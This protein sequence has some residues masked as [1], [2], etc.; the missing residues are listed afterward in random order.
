M[1]KSQQHL[2]RDWIQSVRENRGTKSYSEVVS[3]FVLFFFPGNYKVGLTLGRENAG[4]SLIRGG[5]REGEWEKRNGYQVNS[6]LSIRGF[7]LV[8]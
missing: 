1:V 2:E 3:S 6:C 4:K 7:K 8:W 5:P